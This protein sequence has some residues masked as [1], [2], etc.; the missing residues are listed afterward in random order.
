MPSLLIMSIYQGCTLFVLVIVKICLSDQ[1]LEKIL[2]WS[3]TWSIDWWPSNTESTKFR[4]C[5]LTF[6]VNSQRLLFL[7]QIHI[8]FYNSLSYFKWA[9]L[10]STIIFLKAGNF[11]E[12][13]LLAHIPVETHPRYLFVAKLSLKLHSLLLDLLLFL[14]A[15]FKSFEDFWHIQLWLFFMQSIEDVALLFLLIIS[16][17]DYL[18]CFSE[19]LLFGESFKTYIEFWGSICFETLV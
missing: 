6:L 9:S 11:S 4:A 7:F 2:V 13:W 3:S 17:F 19:S 1:R 16:F 18:S 10:F 15:F 8:G 5:E 12:M 14:E